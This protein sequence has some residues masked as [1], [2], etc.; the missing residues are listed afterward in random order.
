MKTEG[1]GYDVYQCVKLVVN[2]FLLAKLWSQ[3]RAAQIASGD[4]VSNR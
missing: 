2:V 1:D 4:S 3:Q